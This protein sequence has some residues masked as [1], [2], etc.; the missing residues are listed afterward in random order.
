MTLKEKAIEAVNAVFRDQALSQDE[1]IDAL[2][3]IVDL[4]TENICAIKE[5]METGR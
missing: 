2:D 5:D 1:A 4:C 3:A